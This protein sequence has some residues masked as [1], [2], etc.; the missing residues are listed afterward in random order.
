VQ[1]QLLDAVA[2]PVSSI[3]A[4]ECKFRLRSWSLPTCSMNMLRGNRAL[5][6]R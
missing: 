6:A 1:D 5:C 4:P 2:A 3:G